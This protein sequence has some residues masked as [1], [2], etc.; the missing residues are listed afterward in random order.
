MLKQAVAAQLPIVAVRTRD[1]INLANVIYA[2]TGKKPLPWAP[3]TIIAE[4]KVYLHII[5]SQ[6]DA[7]VN[8]PALY[9]K[10]VEAESTLLVVNLPAVPETL[11]DAGEVP[12]PRSLMTAFLKEVMDSATKAEEL[13]RGLGGCTI[14]EAIELVRL[15]MAR[16]K[17][18]TLNG[19]MDTRKSAFQASAG[20]TQVDA[21]QEVYE[22]HAALA[23][24]LK[25]EAPFFLHGE[26]YRLR[27]RGLLFDGPPG[28]GKT[29][30]AKWVAHALGVPLYRVDIGGTKNKYVGSSEQNMLANLGRLDAEEPCVALIDEVEKVF[31]Q[32][33]YD[34]GATTTMLGQLLWWLA[35]HR[36]R[37]LTIMTTNNSKVLPPEL[38]RE[39]RIDDVMWF[40]G[41]TAEDA[42]PFIR[43]VLKTYKADADQAAQVKAAIWKTFGATSKTVSQAAITKAVVSFVKTNKPT[44]LSQS[45]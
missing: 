6:A 16:D 28:T 13:L 5:L 3:N 42:L 19:L 17:S 30:G 15:T 7:K 39:G 8:W 26:D 36:S 45:S 1:L 2:V 23:A 22:P 43:A 14:K 37:V 12:V 44:L 18:L 33:E 4:G 20:L 9:N 35:E 24:W 11:F 10:L 31:G 32:K 40:E 38:Y 34:S 27:P 41:L 29:A 25:R 21:R